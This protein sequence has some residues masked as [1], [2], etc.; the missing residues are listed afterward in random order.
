MQCFACD[1]PSTQICPRCGNHFC[2]DHGA[3]YCAACLDPV[4]AAPSS[5]AFRVALVGLLGASVLAL[6]LLVRPP[7]VPGESSGIIQQPEETANFT[8]ALTPDTDEGTTGPSPSGGASATATPG[9]PTATATPAG[10]PAPTEP[11][12]PLQYTTVDGDTW[13]GVAEQFGVDATALAS[14]NGYTLE[15][16]LPVGVT[17]TIPQ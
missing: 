8:P 16:V 6:W 12:A 11:P 1:R 9:G 15:D 14:A 7:S 5:A 2:I 17:L 10:T 3:A 4:N 13:F